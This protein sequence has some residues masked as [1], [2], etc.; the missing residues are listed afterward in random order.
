MKSS[1]GLLSAAALFAAVP[2][3]AQDPVPAE[4]AVDASTPAEAAPAE[5]APAETAPAEASADAAA[6][7]AGSLLPG[8]FLTTD[9]LGIL[10]IYTKTD[11]ARDTGTADISQGMGIHVIYGHQFGND[12]WGYEVH[13]FSEVLETE[14]VL[15][16][17]FYH[18]GIGADLTY[19]FGDRSKFTPFLLAGG[20]ASY[21]D[22]FPNSGEKDDFDFFLNAGGGFVTAP[23]TEVGFLRIRG[24][25]RYVFDNFAEGYGDIQIGLGI[26][27]PLFRGAVLAPVVT[28]TIQVVEV[29]TGV[30]DTDGDGVVDDSDKCPGTPAGTRV[31]G[32]GCP[33]EK[34]IALKGV[35]FEFNEA[36]LRPD[37]VTILDG[38]TAILKRYPDMQVEVAGHTDNV[39]ADAYNQNLSERR[40]GAVRDYFVEQGVPTTQMTVKGYGEAEPLSDNES[41]EGREL[42][43]R[44]ELRILN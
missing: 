41:E 33:L 43:R 39:G 15:R 31:N 4:T 44:V 13:G 2:V 34:V 3:L 32:E 36:R 28:E 10:G 37:A 40:A 24:E 11:S 25:A 20:G 26:E 14:D 42:N 23:M 21:N 38:A 1:I 7:P 5:A 19:A 30:L 17:D 27:I 22:V 18:Y 35:T 12:G 9:Y 29:P 16:T 6:E 8:G